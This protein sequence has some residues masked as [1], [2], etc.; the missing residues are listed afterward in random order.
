MCKA[1]DQTAAAPPAPDYVK[2]GGSYLG[3][4][5]GAYYGC[6]RVVFEPGTPLEVVGGRELQFFPGTARGAAFP[7][8]GT[9]AQPCGRV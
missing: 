9:C 7:G 6:A 3:L 5:A 2:S 4:C 1:T 8:Q